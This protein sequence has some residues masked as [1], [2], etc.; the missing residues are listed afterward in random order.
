MHNIGPQTK[1]PIPKGIFNY[2][3]SNYI[4]ITLWALEKG[5]AKVERLELA[6]DAVIQTGFGGVETVEGQKW[7]KRKGHIS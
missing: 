7:V 1:F 6:A 5:G 3:G 4:A 2:Y